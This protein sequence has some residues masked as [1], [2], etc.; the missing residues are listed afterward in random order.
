MSTVCVFPEKFS[1]RIKQTLPPIIKTD[2]GLQQLARYI[3]YS[4]EQMK[5]I[6]WS[7]Y[8][9][10]S[11]SFTSTVLSRAHACKSCNNQWYT[12]AQ[13]HKFNNDKSPT[14]RC[15]Q[16]GKSETI[17]HIIGCPSH[18]QTHDDY[19]PQVNAHF[20]AYCIG[21]HLLKALELGMDMITSDAE[22]H[23]GEN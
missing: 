22:S 7:N 11:K 2:I 3:H 17:T 12:Y 16:S 10:T 21:N 1:D 5:L 18:A 19:R 4:E 20:R 9:I 8:H 23:L 14:C 13:A 6:D 15:C